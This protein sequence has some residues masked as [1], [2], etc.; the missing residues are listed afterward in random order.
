MPD[1]KRLLLVTV[2]VLMATGACFAASAEKSADA[3]D[4][5]ET[6]VDREQIKKY[7]SM[8]DKLNIDQILNNTRLMVNNIKCFLNEGPC[9]A[10]LKEM[11]SKCATV[12]Q[13]RTRVRRE[14]YLPR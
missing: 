6:P 12:T 4:K 7:L 8:M 10:Q 9:P 2:L 14:I 5:D 11:K 13:K 3:A 1:L